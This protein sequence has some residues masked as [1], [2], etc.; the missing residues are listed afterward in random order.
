MLKAQVIGNVGYDPEIRQ[1]KSG[2][3]FAAFTVS[4]DKGRDVPPLWV[5][6]TWMG[7]VDSPLLKYVKK[8]AKVCVTGN[9]VVTAYAD[10]QGAPSYGIDIYA[11]SVDI[12]LFAKREEGAQPAQAQAQV[13]APAA[14]QQAP[15]APVQ[16]QRSAQPAALPSGVTG[17]IPVPG[18]QQSDIPYG[19]GHPDYDRL[20]N[21]L[22][23][24]P[25]DMPA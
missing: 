2:H 3:K 23:D 5:R 17:P 22:K 13:Q 1:F 24:D 11:E 19:P 16:Q 4:H 14:Q 8:G 7:G 12:I 18:A 10:R 15:A 9:V 6:V 25:G 20:P 21:F